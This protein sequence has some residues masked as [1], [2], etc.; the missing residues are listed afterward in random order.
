MFGSTLAFCFTH[1]RT[2][3][4]C[5]IQ[6]QRELEK[7]TRYIGLTWFDGHNSL[8]FAYRAHQHKSFSA[9][10]HDLPAAAV[11]VGASQW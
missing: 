6:F 11:A 4:R 5:L 8:R 3:P 9:I 1:W 10:F 2:K 7:W